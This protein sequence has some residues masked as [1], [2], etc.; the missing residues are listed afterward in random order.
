MLDRRFVFLYN[1][2]MKDLRYLQLWDAYGPLLTEHQ[3]EICELYYICDL[4]LTEIAEQKGVS[5]QSVSDA[6]S[7][8]RAILDEYESKLHFN[9]INQESML[10]ISHML[11]R[12]M[13]A[14]EDFKATHPDFSGD[15]D[16]ILSLMT[17]SGEHVS[18][19]TVESKAD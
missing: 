3:R 7:K 14:L 11:T 15:I 13:R 12:T 6:L 4:S 10:E 8:S 9:A 2:S 1:E 16:N 17:I 19:V 5:K 18:T